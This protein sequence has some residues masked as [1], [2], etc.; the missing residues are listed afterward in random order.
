MIGCDEPYE[1]MKGTYIVELSPGHSLQ[2]HCHRIG[3]DMAD[4]DAYILESIFPNAIGYTCKGV[5]DELLDSIRADVG[6]KEVFC[7]PEGQPEP[8]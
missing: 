3:R 6:V 2:D 7:L 4:F 8:E 5:E 1:L